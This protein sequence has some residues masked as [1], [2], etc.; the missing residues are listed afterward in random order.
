MGFLWA[1]YGWKF[2]DTNRSEHTAWRE[3]FGIFFLNTKIKKYRIVIESCKQHGWKINSVQAAFFQVFI[4]NISLLL[5]FWDLTPLPMCFCRRFEV[6][7]FLHIQRDWTVCLIKLQLHPS[8]IPSRCVE[9]QLC[10]H[11]YHILSHTFGERIIF[12]NLGRKLN[13]TL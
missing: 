1:V 9:R 10:R 7:C 2:V 13:Y 12:P 8:Y 4:A 3:E 5:F 6:T 11:I